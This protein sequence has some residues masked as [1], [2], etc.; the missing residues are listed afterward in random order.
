MSFLCKWFGIGCPKPPVPPSP[1]ADRLISVD[2][3]GPTEFVATLLP[4][5]FPPIAGERMVPEAPWHITFRVPG[6]VTGGANIKVTADGWIESIT[7]LSV[8]GKTVDEIGG[9][10]ATNTQCDPVQLESAAPVVTPRQGVPKLAGRVFVDAEGPYLSVG[11]SLFWAPWAWVNDRAKLDEN[12]RYL[13]GRVDYIRVLLA[14]GPGGLWDQRLSTMQS[15]MANDTLR[16]MTNYVYDTYGIRVM[17]TI[18]GTLQ[19]SRA[20]RDAFVDYVA[21]TAQELGG[22]IHHIEPANEGDNNGFTRDELVDHVARIK[23]VY[24][25]VVALTSPVGEHLPQGFVEYYDGSGADLM[26]AHLERDVNGTG[27]MWRPVRQPREGQAT[28]WAWSSNEPIGIGSSVAQDDD[29]LRL[30]MSAAVT[31]LCAGATY[32]VHTAAGIYG[33]AYQAST[34]YRYANL[35]EQPTLTATLDGI[36]TLRRLLPADLP[37]W[38]WL[39]NNPNFPDYPFQTDPL[40]KEDAVLRSFLMTDGTNFVCMPIR[41]AQDTPYIARRPLEFTHY[42]PLTGQVLGQARLQSG[43][44]YILRGAPNGQKAAIFIGRYL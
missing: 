34:A 11:T 36:A 32:V 28:G 30:A 10:P 19:G 17:P 13:Q 44:P 21:R 41:V 22:K 43:E 3:G 2:I 42:D 35:W 39:N 16:H 7:R 9:I 20:D 40:V 24:T 23:R 38:R 27:G 8:N 12:L 14:V 6:T 37:N 1:P 4:D 18:F 29:P 15:V 33:I 26:T 5:L 31:W 25:G